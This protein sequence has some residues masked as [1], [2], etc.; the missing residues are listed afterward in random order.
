MVNQSVKPFDDVRVR[1]AMQMALNLE[2]INLTFFG[3]MG[4]TRP[5]GHMGDALVGYVIPYEQ[6]SDEIK[7][8]Y[9]YDPEGAKMLLDD[10]GLTPGADGIR[11]SAT[12]ELGGSRKVPYAE[13]TTD[14]WRAIGIDVKVVVTDKRWQNIV[15]CKFEVSGFGTARELDPFM[16]ALAFYKGASPAC[17]DNEEHNALVE[18]YQAA[19]T[20]DEQQKA[21]Q[22]IYMDAVERAIHIWGMRLPR[23]NATQ[24]WVIGFNGELHLSDASGL[25]LSSRVWID[26]QMKQAM[27]R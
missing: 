24:P 16:Q 26:S 2:L 10:A 1:R 23:F 14:D 19:T 9:T 11:F 18:A 4:D 17:M 7:G 25:G 3:G 20:A 12:L 27:G 21:I 15:D 6:W 13:L 5:Q 8:Y 22:K